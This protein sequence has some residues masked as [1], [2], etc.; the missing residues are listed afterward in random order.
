METVPAEVIEA[1]VVAE[2]VV[3]EVPPLNGFMLNNGLPLFLGDVDDIIDRVKQLDSPTY[4]IFYVVGTHREKYEEKIG[5][6]TT[7]KWTPHA[8]RVFKVVQNFIGYSID[9]VDAEKLGLTELHP[10][11]TMQLPLIPYELI[12]KVDSFFHSVHKKHGTEAIVLLTYD[13]RLEGPDGWGVLIPTQKNTAAHCKYDPESII[14]D[15]DDEV[16]IVGSMHSHPNMSAYASGTDH[17]D[18]DNNDG[19]HITTG[20]RSGSNVN[21]HYVELQ[22]GGS[23]FVMGENDAFTD[24]PEPPTFPEIDGWL[25]KV[26]TASTTFPPTKG[27]GTTTTLSGGTNM[28]AGASSKSGWSG[29]TPGAD[30]EAYLDQNHKSFKLPEG[31][32]SLTKHTVVV[33][34]LSDQ[35]EDCPVCLNRFSSEEVTQRRRCFSCTCHVLL[36]GEDIKDIV[37]IRDASNFPTFQLVEGTAPYD[38]LLWERWEETNPSDLTSTV[39]QSS[40]DVYF[41]VTQGK[42]L[43]Q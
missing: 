26:E 19:V 8:P 20:W 28:A 25:E 33:R 32:P 4:P 35:E 3:E 9:V 24:A 10:E 30:V 15:K 36:P 5:T 7:V 39:V 31:C 1:E 2:D 37:A 29:Y 27:Y 21:E 11:A 14:D 34:L 42:V 13:P 6:T 17:H 12:Q 16:V 22:M 18:Q 41:E 23:S 38:I 43:A 40:V